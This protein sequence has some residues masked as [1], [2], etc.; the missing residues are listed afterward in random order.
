MEDD[1]H[2]LVSAICYA[3]KPDNM[4]V[5]PCFYQLKK[6]NDYVHWLTGD[7]PAELRFRAPN[8]TVS[9]WKQS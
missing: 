1:R 7:E 6:L 9:P 3:T 2:E 8:K 4:K 5:Q